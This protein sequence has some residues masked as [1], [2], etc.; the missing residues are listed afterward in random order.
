MMS[1]PATVDAWLAYLATLHPAFIAMGL[2]RVRAVLANLDS[3]VAC[4][5]V[6]VAGTR[7]GATTMQSMPASR[8]WRHRPNPVG[9]AS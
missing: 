3:T 9:P 2:D 8:N 5:V 6:T 7:D 4:P 1:R